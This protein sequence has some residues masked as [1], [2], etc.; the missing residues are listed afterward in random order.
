VDVD[1]EKGGVARK[2]QETRIDKIC[3]SSFAKRPNKGRHL[4][5]PKRFDDNPVEE[6]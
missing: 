1:D 3:K 4:K 5:K 2:S 6:D